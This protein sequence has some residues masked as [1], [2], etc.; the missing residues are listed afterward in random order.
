ML[1]LVQYINRWAHIDVHL[2]AHVLSFCAACVTRSRKRLRRKNTHT[3]RSTCLLRRRS[4]HVQSLV[5]RPRK[6]ESVRRPGR[7]A[8][9][10]T[11][12]SLVRCYLKHDLKPKRVRS[13]VRMDT[14]VYVRKYRR[15]STSTRLDHKPNSLV[16][17]EVTQR[18]VTLCSQPL[19]LTRAAWL[20]TPPPQREARE[21][22]PADGG[23]GQRA[24]AATSARSDH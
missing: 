1:T 23:A 13:G 17:R 16:S 11:L 15:G 6:L 9:G 8:S 24:S 4:D 22:R 5:S 20:F 7:V 3:S 12:V 14:C 21:H 10:S 19:S 2:H 18:Q